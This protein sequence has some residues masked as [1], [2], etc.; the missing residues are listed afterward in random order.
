[1]GNRACRSE[2]RNLAVSLGAKTRARLHE[3][4]KPPEPKRWIG[5]VESEQMHSRA[6]ELYPVHLADRWLRAIDYLR[7]HAK[8]GWQLDRPITKEPTK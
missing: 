4:N 1:M 8:R 2:T 6:M 7:R 3:C 5:D